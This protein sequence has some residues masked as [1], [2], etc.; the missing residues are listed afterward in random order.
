MICFCGGDTAILDSSRQV[1]GSARRRHGCMRCGTWFTTYEVHEGIA[2]LSM[3]VRIDF[4]DWNGAIRAAVR[5]PV[6]LCPC[7]NEARYRNPG[8]QTPR[9]CGVCDILKNEGKGER[10]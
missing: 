5:P 10:V 4:E 1:D 3:L 2:T 8:E 7:G 6:Y 9:L